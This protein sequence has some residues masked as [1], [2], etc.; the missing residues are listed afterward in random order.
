MDVEGRRTFRAAIG[1]LPKAHV[2][3]LGASGSACLATPTPVFRHHQVSAIIWAN[4]LLRASI[5]GMQQVAERI[6]ERRP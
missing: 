4:H 1:H 5:V 2:T 6:L 3:V